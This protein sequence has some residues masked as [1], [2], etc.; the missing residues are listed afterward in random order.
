MAGRRPSSSGG[1]EKEGRSEGER[2]QEDGEW[3]GEEMKIGPTTDVTLLHTFYV[4]F[5]D[6]QF[7]KAK[8]SFG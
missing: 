2:Q 6:D 8:N 3:G 5:L 4:H 1:R 7:L